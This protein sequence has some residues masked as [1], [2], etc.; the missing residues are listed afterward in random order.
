MLRDMRLKRFARFLLACVLFDWSSWRQ[1][2]HSSAACFSLSADCFP[3]RS[4]QAAIFTLVATFL[5]VSGPQ[6]MV[7]LPAA[8]AESGLELLLTN[9]WVG[10]GN[11]DSLSCVRPEVSDMDVRFY[12]R[13]CAAHIRSSGGTYCGA[14][15]FRV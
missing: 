10:K 11:L 5:P 2:Q 1:G 9:L 6:D 3:L 4:L 15:C 12:V 7:P 14:L 13:A 8:A